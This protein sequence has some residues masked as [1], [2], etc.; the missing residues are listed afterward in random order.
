MLC[1]YKQPC[2]G[3]G[4]VSES[5]TSDPLIL[6]LT[7]Y[8]LG[9]CIQS[10]TMLCTYQKPCQDGIF[11]FSESLPQVSS[12]GYM[13]T[14]CCKGIAEGFSYFLHT[15]RSSHVTNGKL[16]IL[17]PYGD[18]WKTERKRESSKLCTVQGLKNPLIRLFWPRREKPCLRDVRQSEFQTSL[19]SYSD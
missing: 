2:L 8:Q 19:F 1:T 15:I 3:G 9:S 13:E 7:L 4:G 14:S 17:K 11:K 16:N 6:S 12:L 5:Q 18:S 10:K